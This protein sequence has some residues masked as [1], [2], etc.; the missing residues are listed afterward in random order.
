MPFNSFIFLMLIPLIWGVYYGI[1]KKY[2]MHTLLIISY[3]IYL[4]WYPGYALLL[5]GLTLFSFKLAQIVAKRNDKNHGSGGA[6][7]CHLNSHGAK[8][9]TSKVAHMIKNDF[10]FSNERK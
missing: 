1:P 7:Y 6:F 4:N 10:N 9:Y 5:L 3:L 8:K 2:A